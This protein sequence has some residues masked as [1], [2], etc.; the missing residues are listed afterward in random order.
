MRLQPTCGLAL[1]SSTDATDGTGTRR[2]PRGRPTAFP[3][4]PLPPPERGS[5]NLGPRRWRA[6]VREDSR[7]SAALPKGIRPASVASPGA[8]A[9]GTPPTGPRIPASPSQKHSALSHLVATQYLDCG[10]RARAARARGFCPRP[11][12][13]SCRSRPAWSPAPSRARGGHRRATASASAST[14]AR[15]RGP[16]HGIRRGPPP[17][18][19]CRRSSS[20][21]GAAFA[22]PRGHAAGTSGTQPANGSIA[23]FAPSGASGGAGDRSPVLAYFAAVLRTG[24]GRAGDLGRSGPVGVHSS[25]TLSYVKG[26]GRPSLPPPGGWSRVSVPPGGIVG[27]G[28]APCAGAWPRQCECCAE[29]DERVAQKLMRFLLSSY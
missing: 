26:H 11:R 12:Q 20:P 3:T 28:R 5:R 19:V 25:D 4:D 14:L 18:R 13:R 7:D 8:T 15:A 17:R 6:L 16:S 9:R 29:T 21:Y 27:H 23:G 2:F 22:G 24:A 1:G 10:A